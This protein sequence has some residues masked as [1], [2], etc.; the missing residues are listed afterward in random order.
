MVKQ[1]YIWVDGE[2]VPW[3][4]AVTHVLSHSLHSGMGAFEGVRC[5]ETPHGRAFFRLDAHL[6]RLFDSAKILGV[7]MSWSSEKL[8][9]ACSELMT[10]NNL[11]EAY[12]RP[13]VFLGPGEL[14]VAARSCPTRVSIAAWPWGAY[15]GE[16][17][18]R[19]GVRTWVSSFTRSTVNSWMTKA[20]TTGAYVN[21]VLA[22]HEALDHGCDEAIFLDAQGFVAEGSGENIFIVKKG[23]LYT[24]SLSG[25][26]LAGITRDTLLTLAREEGIPVLE[27]RITRDELYLADECFFT[28]TAA[29][30]TPVREVDDR[31]IGDGKVGP[32]TKRLQARFFDVV[33][34]S[35]NHHPEWHTRG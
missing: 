31:A 32:I 22:K 12:L 21:S 16:E 28:G 17:G 33:K 2:L 34:G 23:R 18:Q 5:Y 24:P 7:K 26:I 3:D 20:K 6:R 4:Q 25:S 11:A 8:A 1:Q 10:R 29:E 30:V 14:G 15:L 27:D 19:R 13:I 35:D 9:E